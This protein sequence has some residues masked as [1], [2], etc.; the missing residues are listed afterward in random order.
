MT[1]PALSVALLLAAGDPAAGRSLF[2]GERPFQAGG[3]PCGA[4]HALGSQGPAFGASLGPELSAALGGMAAADLDPVLEALPFPT[5]TPL[6][7]GRALLPEERADLAAFLVQATQAAPA[8]GAWRFEL[9]GALG[10]VALLA[11]LA[12]AARRR[13]APSRARLLAA[14][15]LNRGG[16][17]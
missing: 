2:I 11:L 8:G 14:A 9:M 1:L 17:R 7:D 12:L 13:K 6:Y 10:A 3:P 5:M 15:A 16:S 4:C